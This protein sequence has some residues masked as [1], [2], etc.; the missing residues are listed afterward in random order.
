MDEAARSSPK[1]AEANSLRI[2]QHKEKA[3][4][5]K[6]EGRYEEAELEI[7]KALE[8]DPAD[9]S[10]RNLL[11]QFDILIQERHLT[12]ARELVRKYRFGDAIIEYQ[13][14]L[15]RNPQSDE[16]ISGLKKAQNMSA[17]LNAHLTRGDEYR[18]QGKYRAAVRE[19]EQ[20]TKLDPLNSYAKSEAE[21]CRQILA[22]QRFLAAKASESLKVAKSKY[23]S[24]R[25]HQAMDEAHEVLKKV[26]AHPDALKLIKESKG[27]I[28]RKRKRFAILTVIVLS[29]GAY[30]YI[31]YGF[32]NYSK[33]QSYLAK[34]RTASEFENWTEVMDLC[35]K[36]LKHRPA[37]DKALALLS[38]SV[39]QL[40]ELA[41]Q[42]R[43]GM[44]GAK[45][46]AEQTN[47]MIHAQEPYEKALENEALAD[48]FMSS[49]Q[50]A[51]AAEYYK[52][53]S[54]EYKSSEETASAAIAKLDQLQLEIMAEERQEADR[55]RAHTREAMAKADREQAHKYTKKN[56]ARAQEELKAGDEK[57]RNQDYT[58]AARQYQ[59]AAHLFQQ[60]AENV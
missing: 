45:H 16:A 41:G 50:Y 28:L 47:A 10:L 52:K 4:A 3:E 49:A 21:Q 15:E 25:Y 34:A 59:E 43:K 30:S 33:Y 42:A 60:S 58:A 14:V 2:A 57:Y 23:E 6:R 53:A 44:V 40:E 22:E 36:A 1:P 7:K 29:I 27:E 48:S 12:S 32:W 13:I 46:R 38:Q 18:K 20:V 51:L 31:L 55:A 56:Y 24:K 19:Y 26:P 8:L 5:C 11:A 35:N 9:D 37:D 54:Q 17:R 39:S